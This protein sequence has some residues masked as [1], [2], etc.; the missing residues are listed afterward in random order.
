MN[1]E[2]RAYI[3]NDIYI[4]EKIILVK[5]LDFSKN[6]YYCNPILRKKYVRKLKYMYPKIVKYNEKLNIFK[7]KNNC[8]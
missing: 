5:L 4:K 8:F 3:L 1:E 7:M 6:I 2:D